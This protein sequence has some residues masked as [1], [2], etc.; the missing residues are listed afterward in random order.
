MVVSEMDKEHEV[1]DCRIIM[2]LS[3]R[4]WREQLI[5]FESLNAALVI[6]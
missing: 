4:D 5:S 2:R 1:P 6:L 3:D